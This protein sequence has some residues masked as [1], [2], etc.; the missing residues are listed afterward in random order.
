MERLGA[1]RC[2]DRGDFLS[3]DCDK[4]WA[5]GNRRFTRANVTTQLLTGWFVPFESR[6]KPLGSVLQKTPQTFR[7]ESMQ[8]DGSVAVTWTET[9]FS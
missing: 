2:C 3:F 4:K 5:V 1:L 9:L 7:P 8:V 6:R